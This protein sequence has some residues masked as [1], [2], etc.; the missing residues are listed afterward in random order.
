MNAAA[1]SA[2]VFSGVNAM[3]LEQAS[4]SGSETYDVEIDLASYSWGSSSGCSGSECYDYNVEVV[5]TSCDGSS[6]CTTPMCDSDDSSCI[7][8]M[9]TCS[10]SYCCYGSSCVSALADVNGQN[11]A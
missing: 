2:M 8:M 11:L 7:S 6:S 5:V 3:D 4:S 10:G 9:I 1:L